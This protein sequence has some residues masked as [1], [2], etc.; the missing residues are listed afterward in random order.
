MAKIVEE[1]LD[2]IKKDYINLGFKKKEKTSL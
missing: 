1:I 2:F